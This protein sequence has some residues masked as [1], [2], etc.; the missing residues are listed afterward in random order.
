MVCKSFFYQN[1]S[2]RIT[3]RTLGRNFS[4]TTIF[5]SF[6]SSKQPPE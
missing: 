3:A 4:K 6:S 2:P 1:Y 5:V